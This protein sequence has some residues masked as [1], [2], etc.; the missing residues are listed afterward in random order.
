MTGHLASLRMAALRLAVLLLA[1][2]A[3]PAAAQVAL[4]PQ[5]YTIDL[6][7]PQ[8]TYAFR[9]SNFTPQA[10]S[11]VVSAV[12]WTMTRHGRVLR[13]PMREQSLAPWLEVSPRSFRVPAHGS[14]V[15]RFAVRA[16]VPLRP[17]EHRAMLYFTERRPAAAAAGKSM[18]I[19]LFRFG[20]AIYALQPPYVSKGR[21]ASVHVDASGAQF[22]LR[23]LGDTTVRMEGDYAVRRRGQARPLARGRLPLG[24]CLPGAL[25]DV[26]LQFD[27]R[28]GLPPGAYVLSLHG[29][30]G[31]QVIARKVPFRVRAPAR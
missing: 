6:G 1:L 24:P 5:I 17:G 13:L 2:P 29:A 28:G 10:V 21:I 26:A 12:N 20:A 15:V 23:N 9:L 16:D 27:V 3:V 19:S 14:Q 18:F 11:V 8:R 4:T 25:R 31:T 7:K 22:V 30:M